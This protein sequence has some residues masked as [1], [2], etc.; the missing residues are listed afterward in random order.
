MKE[1]IKTTLLEFDKSTFLIDLVKYEEGKL[2]VEIV[3]TIK[4]NY[5]EYSQ[6]TIKIK[7]IVL[8]DVL[9][10]LDEYLESIYENDNDAVRSNKS[11]RLSD[12]K[13]KEIVNRYLKGI[14]IKDI[15]LQFNCSE[16]IIEQILRNKNIAII[17]NALE[18]PQAKYRFNK[19]SKK[20]A[21][22]KSANV[23]A[24]EEY[25]LSPLYVPLKELR[26]KLS[27]EKGIPPFLVFTDNMLKKIIELEPRTEADLMEILYFAGPSGKKYGKAIVEII[28][29]II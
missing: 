25:K 7:P 18:K 17:S 12:P 5:G 9:D 26:K 23:I 10:V 20:N 4:D 19:P 14:S 1:I 13:K 16:L 15:A 28:R 2:Y 8:D 11:K 27:K 21:I 29:N 24:D 6:S 3:Q 22:K